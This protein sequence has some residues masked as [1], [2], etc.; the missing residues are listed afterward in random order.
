MANIYSQIKFAQKSVQE[1]IDTK[2]PPIY[3]CRSTNNCNYSEKDIGHYCLSDKE[4]TQE[5]QKCDW[6]GAGWNDWEKCNSPCKYCFCANDIQCLGCDKNYFFSSYD[7][8]YVKDYTMVCEIECPP[9]YLTQEL[10]C[11]KSCKGGYTIYNNSVCLPYSQITD[12]FLVT[13]NDSNQP[14]TIFVDCPQ[15]CQTC[16]SQTH[17]TRSLNHYILNQ[18]KCLITCYPQYLYIDED[19]VNHCLTSCDPNDYLYDNANIDGYSIR[20]CFKNKCGSIQ[21]NQKQQTYLH[22]TKPH[23]CVYPCDDQ[24]YFQQNTDQ[25]SK[26]NSI[27]QDCQNS[28]NF[29]NKCWPGIFLQDN[30]CFT[31]C[32]SKFKNYMNN[33]CEGSCSNGFTLNEIKIQACVS[34]CGEI[35]SIFTYVLNGQCFQNPPTTGAFCIGQQCYNCFINA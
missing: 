15:V 20:Q 35:F 3:L 32:Q 21:I 12:N 29:C 33:Q 6:R 19:D 14:K 7:T 24:Y 18:N 16:T 26:C 22:Q 4:Q 28:A 1:N 13:N 27:C 31:S 30:S 5:Y 34:F 9:S 17:C 25:C 8:T 2:Q 11:V 10:E 23:T